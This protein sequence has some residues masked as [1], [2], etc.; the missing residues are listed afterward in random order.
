MRQRSTECTSAALLSAARPGAPA[1][2]GCEMLTWNRWTPSG[3]CWGSPTSPCVPVWESWVLPVA[4]WP[5][6]QAASSAGHCRLNCTYLPALVHT[7]FFPRL[8]SAW[9]A[10]FLVFFLLNLYVEE[11]PWWLQSAGIVGEVCAA[12]RYVKAL[13]FSVV[14]L[15][16]M[17]HCLDCAVMRWAMTWLQTNLLVLQEANRSSS[18]WAVQEATSMGPGSFVSKLQVAAELIPP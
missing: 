7:L 16:Y 12:P 17:C 6:E 2:K 15:G 10:G 5:M 11:F 4:G 3:S 13:H 8:S 9:Q 18:P 14:L 1:S